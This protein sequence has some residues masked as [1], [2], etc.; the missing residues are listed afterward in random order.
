MPIPHRKKE[1]LRHPVRAPKLPAISE[2]GNQPIDLGIGGG[3]AGGE[4][5]DTGRIKIRLNDDHA[6]QVPSP[7]VL[8]IVLVG[9][10]RI[11]LADERGLNFV[12]IYPKV[13]GS[14]SDA[15]VLAERLFESEPSPL[16]RR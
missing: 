16:P 1:K 3:P 14:V 13:S 6:V 11:I 10:F 5:H 15:D 9:G 12:S 7:G 8:V 2:Q 4:A